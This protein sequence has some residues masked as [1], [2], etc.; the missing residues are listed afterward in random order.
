M[1]RNFSNIYGQNYNNYYDNNFK[2]VIDAAEKGIEL[3]YKS[4]DYSTLSLWQQY[5]QTV[6]NIVSKNTRND[7]LK[8]YLEFNLSILM[9]SPSE[10]VKRTVEFLI[11]IAKLV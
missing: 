7:F 6:M 8:M 5:V 1:Y 10:Q 4:I 9:Y 2:F 11:K 3:L